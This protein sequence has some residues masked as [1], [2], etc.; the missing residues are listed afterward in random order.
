MVVDHDPRQA[1]TGARWVSTLLDRLVDGAMRGFEGSETACF[2]A[3]ASSLRIVGLVGKNHRIGIEGASSETA[4]RAACRYNSAWCYWCGPARRIASKG[5]EQIRRCRTYATLQPE[6]LMPAKNPRVS[7]VVDKAL[8][9]WLRS[10]AA[11]QGIS[12]SLIVRD[13]LLRVR[14]EEEERYWAAAGEERLES[15]SRGEAIEHDDA[16]S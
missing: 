11:D 6:D 5:F 4:G 2:V 14:N 8:M 15:F 10:K 12:V 9:K 1:L 7:A 3:R 16:W 13:I